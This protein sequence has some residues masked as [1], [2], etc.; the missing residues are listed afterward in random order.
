MPDR[1]PA[2]DHGPA[3]CH[4]RHRFAMGFPMRRPFPLLLVGVIVLAMAWP[5]AALVALV[6]DRSDGVAVQPTGSPAAEP[7]RSSDAEPTGATST[8]PTASPTP[9]PTPDPEAPELEVTVVQT[10]LSVPWDLA[11]TPDGTMLVTERRGRLRVFASGEK[12]AE[13]LRT[14]EIPD[15]R[16]VGESGTMGIDVDVDFDANPF[17]YVCSSR[18]ADGDGRREPWVNELLRYT[19]G[20]DGDLTLDGPLF[21]GPMRARRQHNGCA[22]EM[23][24]DRRLW[25]SMGDTGAGPAGW[26]QDPERLHG[27]ILRINADGSVPDDNPVW[28]GATEP[29][30]AY[31]M[32]HRNPQGIAIHPATGQ[33]YA[34]EH[35]TGVDDEINRIVAGSNYGWACYTGPGNPGRQPPEECGPAEDYTPPAWASGEPTLATSGAVFL[36]GEQWGSWEGS[37]IVSTLKEQDLRRF[38]LSEDGTTLQEADVLLDQEFGR[39][40][41]AVLGPDGALYVTTSN[42]S[43]GQQPRPEIFEDLIIRVAPAS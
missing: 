3:A 7:T 30:Y 42:F 4:H 38:V 29:S 23:D 5:I 1:R 16:A 41:G 17:V 12:D 21:D 37:L 33:V 36:E 25:I 18:D 19:V 26:P 32:G 20:E 22:V 27:K 43:N 10:G 24:A 28:P 8:E 15:V 13:L 34:S 11:F 39:L 40:R 35:G 9:R 6:L 14:I 31:S 2:V